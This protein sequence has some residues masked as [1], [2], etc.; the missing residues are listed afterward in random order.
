MVDR[1]TISFAQTQA[2]MAA[3]IEK[4]TRTPGAT[5][6][7]GHRR[8]CREP[9]GVRDHGQPAA[10]HASP[11][12]QE[13]VHSRHHGAEQRRPRRVAEDAGADRR[14][15]RRRPDADAPPAAESWSAPATSAPRGPWPWA[16]PTPTFT[17]TSWAASGWAAT[18]RLNGT[19]SLPWLA[20]RRWMYSK[21][22]TRL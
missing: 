14:R 3:M 15:L 5:R 13:G 12:R 22:G 18:P 16:R 2:A 6:L 9:V 17:R 11:R 4:A 10:V 20:S 1:P 19:R 8:C 21:N 7:D